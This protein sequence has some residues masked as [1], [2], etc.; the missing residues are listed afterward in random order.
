[1]DI[2]HFL[3]RL[4]VFALVAVLAIGALGCSTDSG[5]GITG[6]YR[7]DTLTLLDNAKQLIDMPVGTDGREELQQT[8]RDQIND[9]AARYRRNEEVAGSRSFTTMQTALNAL[10]GYYSSPYS[11]NRPLP[12]KLKT[13]LNQEFAQVERALKRGA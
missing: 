9:Y 3:R 2:K 6:D 10:A 12:D 13:R 7:Q 11:I 1:M 4:C 5:T 8:V